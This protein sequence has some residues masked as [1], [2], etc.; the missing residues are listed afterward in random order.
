MVHMPVPHGTQ[1]SRVTSLQLISPI[2]SC[3]PRGFT[4]FDCV[5]EAR[6]ANGQHAKTRLTTGEL[7]IRVETSLYCSSFDGICLLSSMV[8]IMFSVVPRVYQ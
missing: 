7:P 1:F 6:Y 5:R 8:W 2:D 4:K 3:G